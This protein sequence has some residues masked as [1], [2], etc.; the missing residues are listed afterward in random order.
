MHRSVEE[1]VGVEK[2]RRGNHLW[3]RR[4]IVKVNFD[5]IRLNQHNSYSR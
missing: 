3:S 2:F 5:G 1:V 4:E